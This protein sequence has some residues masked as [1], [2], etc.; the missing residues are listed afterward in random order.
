MQY[1]KS[2]NTD[3]NKAQYGEN[4]AGVLALQKSLNQKYSG[5]AGY[6]PLKEDGLYGDLTK[7]AVSGIGGAYGSTTVDEIKKNTG[8]ASSTVNA[9]E[10]DANS[11]ELIKKT[12]P[13]PNITPEPDAKKIAKEVLPADLVPNLETGKTNIDVWGETEKEKTKTLYESDL[14][15]YDSAYASDVLSINRIFD[16]RIEQK[17]KIDKLNLDRMKAYGISNSQYLPIEYTDSVTN[18]E[19]ET[20]DAIKKYEVERQDLLAKAKVARDTGKSKALRDSMDELNKVEERMR[21]KIKDALLIAEAQKKLQQDAYEDQKKKY[22]EDLQN[23]AKK[24]LAYY[25]DEYSK[26]K[27]QEEK[28]KIILKALS[29]YGDQTDQNQYVQA[30]ALFVADSNEREKTALETEKA[31]ASIESTKSTTAKRYADMYKNPSGEKPLTVTEKNKIK[32]DSIAE[33]VLFL[34]DLKKGKNWKGVNP[35]AYEQ[36]KESI[37]KDFGAKAVID[38]ENEFKKKGLKIDYINK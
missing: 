4:S 6:T 20:A 19:N 17:K 24:A 14:A 38:F 32:A 12:T 2:T 25:G 29:Q 3:M 5:Q 11:N 1:T 13:N 26:A 31:K 35:D 15:N 33:G 10:F 8:Y 34:E 18:R 9:G 27:T 36:I 37:K 22:L 28:D 23:V 30:K 16:E 7:G 21:A